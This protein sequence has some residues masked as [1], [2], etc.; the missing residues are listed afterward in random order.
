MEALKLRSK[1]FFLFVVITLALLSIGIMGSNYVNA[2]KK[3]IDRVYFGSLIPVTELNEIVQTYNNPLSYSI[4][5][6]SRGLISNDE[7][8]ESIRTNIAKILSNWRSYKSHYKSDDEMEYVEYVDSEIQNTNRYFYK[9][10]TAAQEGRDLEKLSLQT[11]ENRLSNIHNVLRKLINYETQVAHYERKNFLTNYENIREEIGIVLVFVIFAITVIMWYFFQNIQAEHKKI[12]YVAKKLKLVNKKLQNA[13]YID[14]LTN[15]HNRRYF[16]LVYE[17]ELK[18]AKRAKNYITFMM[19]DI[20]YFKQYNDTYGHMEGDKALQT[21]AKVLKQTLKRPSDFV[22]RLGG[23]EF[24][25]LLSETNE[26]DSATIARKLCDA[27]RG[28]KVVHEKSQANEYLT[29]SVGVVCCIA[30]EALENELLISKAD[31]MLYKAKEKGRDRYVITSSV[32]R[33][34]VKATLVDTSDSHPLSQCED[35]EFG[36]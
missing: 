35:V 5:Q 28:C 14:S 15:L 21:V 31:D 9:I 3:N 17:R 29:I 4:Y 22:F 16:N 25:V 2:M 30:D 27:V 33:A 7:V 12:E 36:T 11:L 6:A 10:L 24:G 1:L 8:S 18:R 13:S 23:E 20:D 32:M 19:I 26:T 34:K